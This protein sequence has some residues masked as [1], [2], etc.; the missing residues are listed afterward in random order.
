MNFT[1]TEWKASTAYSANQEILDSNLNIQKV[2]TAGQSGSSQPTWNATSGGTTTDGS[3]GLV[4]TNQGSMGASAN[5]SSAAEVGGTSGIII[6]N[7]ST[8]T[9]ASQVYFSTLGTGTCGGGCGVQASQAG[10]H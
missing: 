7:T 5:A 6:D 10:L 1:V 3:N 2:T 4:W 8:S 9:G